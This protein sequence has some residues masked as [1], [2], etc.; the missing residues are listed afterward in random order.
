M[1]GETITYNV[2]YNVSNINDSIRSTQRML[3]F[4]NA[5]RLSI[6][7]MQQV[8]A[9]PTFANVMWTSVQ[10]TRV[11][12]N[13]YRMI[14]KTNKA[15][16]AS[17]AAGILGV[18]GSKRALGLMGTNQAMNA[19]FDPTWEPQKTLWQTVAGFVSANPYAV[20]GAVVALAVA[21]VVAYDVRQ[22]RMHKDWQVKQREAAKAQ[23]FEY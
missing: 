4:T 5:L 10:L 1:S 3:Y 12:T 14:D 22:K 7:D 6:T 15:Q 2:V 9:G 16:A 17:G 18:G 8:M 21:G 13:L 11:W 20:G 23:G 19:L